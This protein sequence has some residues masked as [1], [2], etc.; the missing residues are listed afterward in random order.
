MDKITRLHSARLAVMKVDL[1][2]IRSLQKK[3]KEKTIIR[4]PINQ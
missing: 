3:I 1:A 2:Y 4:L